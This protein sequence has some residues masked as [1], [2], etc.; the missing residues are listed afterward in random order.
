ML[1]HKTHLVSCK[2]EYDLLR[3]KINWHKTLE[4]IQVIDLK[5]SYYYNTN[6]SR[7]ISVR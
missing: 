4:N 1:R 5:Q 3:K 7:I 2:I 6:Y